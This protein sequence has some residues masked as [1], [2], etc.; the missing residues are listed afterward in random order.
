MDD[1]KI[2]SKAQLAFQKLEPSPGDVIVIKFPDD[3]AWEQMNLFGQGLKQHIAR[4]VT[5]LCTYSG[6]EVEK[7]NEFQ[8]KR[9]GWVREKK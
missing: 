1:T 6:I 2:Y 3:M 9:F 4:G 7:F 8:M 5:V